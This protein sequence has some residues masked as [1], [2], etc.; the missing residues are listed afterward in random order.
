[1]VAFVPSFILVVVLV[2]GRNSEGQQV[3]RSMTGINI[4]RLLSSYSPSKLPPGV[5]SIAGPSVPARIGGS[6]TQSSY[7]TLDW[8]DHKR[9]HYSIGN[10]NIVTFN[11]LAPCYKRLPI[12]NEAT[13]QR[14]REEEDANMWKTRARE[15]L[16]F[17]QENILSSSSIVA[18]QEFWLETEYSQSFERIFEETGYELKKLRRSSSR[19][20]AVALAIKKEFFTIMGGQD[21]VL[22]QIGH[23]VALLLWIRHKFTGKDILIANTHLSFP[24]S[25]MERINQM[26]QMRKLTSVIDSFAM[27]N[28]I[29]GATR[30]I[31]GDFNVVGES[32]VCDHLRS[33]GYFS[34]LEISPPKNIEEST[35]ISTLL[36]ESR[37]VLKPLGNTTLTIESSSRE[38]DSASA[39]PEVIVESMNPISRYLVPFV[40]H[41]THEAQSLGVDHIFVKPQFE[42]RLTRSFDED[43]SFSREIRCSGGLFVNGTEVL[44]HYLASNVWQSEFNISDHRPVGASLVIGR[45]YD[46]SAPI[47]N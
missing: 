17:F 31:L 10:F 37:E 11:L 27:N 5:S 40:S 12:I 26:R 44:P 9:T 38:D 16:A 7:Q 21:I 14:I 6:T 24:H 18:L 29:W 34:C 36:P 30:I 23:R 8:N 1:M 46:P 28:Q 33:E 20:D 4:R 47:I 42:C 13:H 25:A 32:P 2:L 39:T 3:K 45:Q 15:T 41:K 19:N 22:C 35:S 43:N